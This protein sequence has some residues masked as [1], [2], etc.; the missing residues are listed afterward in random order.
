MSSGREQAFLEK[1]A[2]S[3]CGVYNE[4]TQKIYGRNRRT[5]G[6]AV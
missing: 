6:E 3:V 5:I 1:P 4:G 2:F